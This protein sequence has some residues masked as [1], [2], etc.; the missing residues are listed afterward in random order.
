[1]LSLSILLNQIF[2][3]FS[4]LLNYS[5]ITDH[6][7]LG[8]ECLPWAVVYIQAPWAAWRSSL[9]YSN[10]GDGVVGSRLSYKFTT[11][12]AGR[13]PESQGGCGQMLYIL[14]RWGSDH[15]ST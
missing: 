2:Y 7:L 9:F 14:D 12:Q 13:L 10:A 4:Q 1:M 11:V 3:Y 5:I 15:A 8:S 6:S